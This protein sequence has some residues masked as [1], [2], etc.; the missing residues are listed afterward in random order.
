MTARCVYV[1]RQMRPEVIISI[2]SPP[3]WR[4]CNDAQRAPSARP[5]ISR[6]FCERA[7]S[8]SVLI[9]KSGGLSVEFDE[10]DGLLNGH[11]PLGHLRFS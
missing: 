3:H 6:P 11:P 7:Q 9:V 5:G 4:T 2:R 10:G 1:D 8:P